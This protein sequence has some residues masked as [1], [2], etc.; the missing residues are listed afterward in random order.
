MATRLEAVV[1]EVAEVAEELQVV[2]D[3]GVAPDLGGVGDVRVAG[4]NQG[5]GVGPPLHAPD[6]RVGVAVLEAQVREPGGAKRQAHVPCDGVGVAVSGPVGAGVQLE[7]PPAG[8]FLS[9]K[10]MTPAMPSEPYWAEAPS[11]STS[12]CLRALVGMVEMSGP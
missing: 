1:G 11:R 2:L 6:G 7:L 3:H 4:G 10:L 8:A 9:S 12:T 5:G